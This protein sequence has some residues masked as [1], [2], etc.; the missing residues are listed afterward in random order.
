[1]KAKLIFF[2]FLIVCQSSFSL[3]VG[4]EFA[5]FVNPDQNGKYVLSKNVIG[6][7]WVILDFFATTCEPCEKERPELE[8]IQEIYGK[9]NLTILLFATDPEGREIV[10]PYFEQNPTTLTVVLDP[11]GVSAERYGVETIPTLFLI[12]DEGIIVLIEVGYSEETMDNVKVFLDQTE[13]TSSETS[14]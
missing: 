14:S 1:M 12:N 5:P 2:S 7:G 13:A 11:F 6:K 8:E 3:D 9:E 10:T 4:D